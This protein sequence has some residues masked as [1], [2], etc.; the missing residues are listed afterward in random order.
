MA[1]PGAGRFRDPENT[2]VQ[3]NEARWCICVCLG[4]RAVVAR[5]NA[6][7]QHA[8][9][10][11]ALQVAL[12]QQIGEAL[13]WLTY[14]KLGLGLGRGRGL[15]GWQGS[16]LS[17]AA[18]T[19]AAKARRRHPRRFRRLRSGREVADIAL[20]AQPRSRRT[21]ARDPPCHKPLPL[22]THASAEARATSTRHDHGSARQGRRRAWP[23]RRRHCHISS[24]GPRAARAWEAGF[25]V[26]WP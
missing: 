14:A 22:G 17:R 7:C 1:K 21:R 3:R 20:R 19:R 5:V 6:Y 13:A 11:K 23:R 18:R 4:P 16:C 10:R 8:A 2:K 26:G 25:E 9:T 15:V 24:L 12:E